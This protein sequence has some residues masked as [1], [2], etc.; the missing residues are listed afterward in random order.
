MNDNGFT[1]ARVVPPPHGTTDP[2]TWA[3][4]LPFRALAAP[5]TAAIMPAVPS[6]ESSVDSLEH[7]LAYYACLQAFLTYS[8]GWTRPDKGLFWWYSANRPTDEARLALINATWERDGTLL[9]F[10]AWLSTRSSASMAAATLMPWREEY[11]TRPLRLDDE[12]RIRLR[13]EL[14]RPPWNGGSD[15]LHLGGGDHVSEPS[16]T[17]ADTARARMLTIDV[18][19]RRATYTSETIMGWYA[20]LINAADHLPPL[21]PGRSWRVDVHVMPIGFL[22]TYRRSRDTGLWFAGKH[23]YHMVGN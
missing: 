15:P 5:R 12:W 8:F 16:H 23:S 6:G 19:R 18:P 17:P 22:G 20:G 11:D 1:L 21:A 7:Q 9:G 3:I 13:R 14:S 2:W 4:P 10:L